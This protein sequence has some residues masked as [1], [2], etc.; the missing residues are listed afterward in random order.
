MRIRNGGARFSVGAVCAALAAGALHAQDAPPPR[1]G[2]GATTLVGSL[3]NSLSTFVG[4]EGFKRLT[5]D[6][7]FAARIDAAFYAAIA[8]QETGCL[9][10]SVVDCDTRHLGAVGTVMATAL[11]GPRLSSGLRPI[12]LLFGAGVGVTTWGGGSYCCN[13]GEKRGVGLG[14]TV[15]I[16]Q[17]GLGSEFR[18]F[19][20]DRIELRMHINTRAPNLSYPE[21]GP[22]YGGALSL[23]LG[24]VW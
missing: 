20:A 1:Y 23:A 17:A 21:S 4:V 6:P 13:G 14:P 15:A 11:V 2:L 12:Y 24:H 16:A 19:G 7:I 3:T 9:L 8:T 18:L 5:S 10:D 22:N